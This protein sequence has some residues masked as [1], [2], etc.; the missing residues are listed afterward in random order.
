MRPH[1]DRYFLNIAREVAQRATC[2]RAKC[3]TVLVDPI[4]NH[5]LATGYNG[6]PPGE[7]HCID[8]GCLMVDGHC[9]R[10]I[11][12]EVNAI[13]HAARNGIRIDGAHAYVYG[14]RQDGDVKQVCRECEKVIKAANV[15][16][17]RCVGES[18]FT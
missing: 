17:I 10:A 15:T 7:V 4:T 9:Q 1:W 5:I 12:S 6:A 2:P 8:E 18:Y 11:H 16:V 14:N 13:A 3:G